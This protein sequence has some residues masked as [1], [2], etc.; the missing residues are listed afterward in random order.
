MYTREHPSPE[1][2]EAVRLGKLY[3]ATHKTFSGRHIFQSFPILRELCQKY[4][5]K[6]IFDYGIGKAQNL[7]YGEAGLSFLG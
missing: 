6:S 3:H 1:Y 5:T 4:Q 7:T 2:I